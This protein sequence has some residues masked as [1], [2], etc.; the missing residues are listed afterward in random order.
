M[1]PKN[2][3]INSTKYIEL[4]PRAAVLIKAW[5]R[6]FPIEI[7]NPK[8]GEFLRRHKVDFRVH[9]LDCACPWG[10]TNS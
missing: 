1:H 10:E 6:R 8:T 9:E 2:L 3:G 5:D 7:R 4:K